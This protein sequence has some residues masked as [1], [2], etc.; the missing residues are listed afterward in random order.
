L[1]LVDRRNRVKEQMQRVENI[2]AHQPGAFRQRANKKV[3]KR[4]RPGASFSPFLWFFC[5]ILITSPYRISTSVACLKKMLNSPG[6]N[7]LKTARIFR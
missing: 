2:P 4:E 7:F 5:C 1:F 3:I 6:D